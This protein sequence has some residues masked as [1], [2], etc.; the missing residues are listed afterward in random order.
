M[1][2]GN[3]MDPLLG[4]VVGTYFKTQIFEMCPFE[5]LKYLISRGCPIFMRL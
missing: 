3:E 4:A 1:V 2:G 5:S